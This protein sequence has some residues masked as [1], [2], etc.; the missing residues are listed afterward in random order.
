[1]Q[2][3][4]PHPEQA[5]DGEGRVGGC[6]NTC[7]S[8]AN[9]GPKPRFGRS[10]WTSGPGPAHGRGKGNGTR[11]LTNVVLDHPVVDLL[12][13]LDVLPGWLLVDFLSWTVRAQDPVAKAFR[14]CRPV[15]G[16]RPQLRRHLPLAT[17]PVA[18]ARLRMVV[19]S[20]RLRTSLSSR[21]RLRTLLFASCRANGRHRSFNLRPDRGASARWRRSGRG[22]RPRHGAGTS[23]RDP[24]SG[25]RSARRP[26]RLRRPPRSAVRRALT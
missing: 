20:V 15:F 22:R 2:A 11:V 5:R 17:G 3:G 16:T 8:R 4:A 25:P 9:A 21:H 13:G 12:R 1:M 18:P 14:Q 26:F 10:A 7:V 6:R 24:V 19:H 23:R